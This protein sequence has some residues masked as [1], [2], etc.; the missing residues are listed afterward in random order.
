M[1]RRVYE[2]P[3]HLIDGIAAHRSAQGFGSEVEAVRDLLGRA[4][5]AGE[6]AADLI[7]RHAVTGDDRIF[8][9]HPAVG[10]MDFRDGLVVSIMDRD[11][12]VHVVR[13]AGSGAA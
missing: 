9:G 4:I 13:T 12:H 5:S 10:S 11:G 6:S 7:K 3:Q 8:C 1:I 2:L